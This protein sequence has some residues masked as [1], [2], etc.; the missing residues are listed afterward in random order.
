MTSASVHTV[1]L[2]L[3]SSK[4]GLIQKHS[5]AV[6]GFP[7]VRG[8]RR[9][10]SSGEKDVVFEIFHPSA[11]LP[12]EGEDEPRAKRSRVGVRGAFSLRLMTLCS[13]EKSNVKSIIPPNWRSAG[14]CLAIWRSIKR[15]LWWMR[16]PLQFI[17]NI[18]HW[19]WLESSEGHLKY[20]A[21]VFTLCQIR[22][23]NFKSKFMK[24][25]TS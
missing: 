1:S 16:T 17:V 9:T 6:S 13:T 23:S 14:R 19:L 8:R 21:D 11:W 24:D 7:N 20:E 5:K 12:E 4:N 3:W 22:L 18:R 15:S 2:H 10:N 25:Q